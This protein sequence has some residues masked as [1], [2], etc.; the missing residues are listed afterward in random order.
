MECCIVPQLTIIHLTRHP[1][2]AEAPQRDTS[3][4]LYTA[5][6]VA[7]ATAITPVTD[8]P[9][10]IVTAIVTTLVAAALLV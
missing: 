8:T 9:A 6:T 2:H 3:S 5:I 10:T 7:A 1:S 4:L